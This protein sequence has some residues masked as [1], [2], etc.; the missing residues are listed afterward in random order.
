[1]VL[2]GKIINFLGDSITYGAGVADEENIYTKRIER[3]YSLT[4]ANSY[5]IGG[6]GYA[7]GNQYIKNGDSSFCARVDEMDESADV[8]VVF[9]GTNDWGHGV[10]QVGD[11]D[12]R[13][14]KTF[15]GS[16]HVLF[17]KL[18]EKYPGKPIVVVTPLHRDIENELHDKGD[19][20]V[21]LKD[22]VNIIRTVAEYYS[23]PVCDLYAMSGLQ[24]NV[25]IIREKF[26]PDGLHP[27]DAGHEIIAERIANFLLDL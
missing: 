15:Y 2:T 24:P 25:P 22:Y 10:A 8:V 4:C 26:I 16:C 3:D 18:I 13:T 1:M 21:T 11:F 12:D 6:T 7:E 5:G 20:K 23:L 14:D 17:T 9:G 27:N 19:R